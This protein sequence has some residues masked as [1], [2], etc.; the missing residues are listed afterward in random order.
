[1]MRAAVAAVWV[2]GLAGCGPVD[3]PAREYVT[4]L[5]EDAEA[6]AVAKRY[7]PSI[8]A[9]YGVKTR[10]QI[11]AVPVVPPNQRAA[12]ALRPPP[13]SA[14]K[15][16]VALASRVA[17]D[18]LALVAV[19]WARIA[20][21]DQEGAEVLYGRGRGE[22]R[23]AVIG[24][25]SLLRT[26]LKKEDWEPRR[27]R[28]LLHETGHALGQA[29]CDDAW[30]LMHDANGPTELDRVALMPCAV[31]LASYAA[32]HSLEPAAVRAA[33]TTA[34]NA[35]GWSIDPPTK[36]KLDRAAAGGGAGGAKEQSE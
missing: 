25:G 20:A 24:L 1:M 2:A 4:F 18:D 26:G 15:I 10:V 17:D 29:H 22:G 6:A 21:G 23:V 27:A 36:S 3:P 31:C 5:A 33:A 28:V 14:D 9:T 8:E 13:V 35:H 34:A 7:L 32:V 12:G 16:L 30:C 11:G 19:T